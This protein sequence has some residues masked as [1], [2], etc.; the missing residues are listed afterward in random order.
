MVCAR[1]T[2]VCPCTRQ[3]LVYLALTL[4]LI[5]LRQGLVSKKEP[6][7][8][9][10]SEQTKIQQNKELTLFCSVLLHCGKN[11]RQIPLPCWKAVLLSRNQGNLCACSLHKEQGKMAK[12]TKRCCFLNKY[13]TSPWKNFI[14]H[15]CKFI[16]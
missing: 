8:P 11:P 5:A 12:L 15:A 6:Q 7:A 1:C 4:Y 16:G 2:C 3:G 9:K 14:A 13:F 10:S